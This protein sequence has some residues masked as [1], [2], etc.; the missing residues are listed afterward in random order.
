MGYQFNWRFRQ[1][2][3]GKNVIFPSIYPLHLL[4]TAF[5]SMDFILLCRFI[6]LS[7][8]SPGVRGPRARGLPPTSFRFYLA[9][10]TLVL[11]YSYCYLRHSGLSPYR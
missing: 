6:Q 7:L 11:S 2:S 3:P 8:A 5:G 9:I 10:D 4:S 1:A